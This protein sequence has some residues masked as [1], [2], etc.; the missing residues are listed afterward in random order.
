LKTKILLSLLL[1][2]W[3][4]AFVLVYLH[5]DKVQLV[6]LPPQS[7][8]EWYKPQN[9]RQVWLHNMFKLRREMQAVRRYAAAQDPE[10]LETWLTDLSSHYLKIREMV[11]EWGGRLD[12]GSLKTLAVLQQAE[13]YAKI[14]LALNRLQESCD[15][16]H[17]Q[18]RAVTATLYRAPDFSNLQIGENQSLKESMVTLNVQ[19]NDIKIS[20]QQ[21]DVNQ[22]LGTLDDL[23]QG[24]D[25]TGVLCANCHRDT[26][27]NYPDESVLKA[28]DVLQVRLTLGTLKQQG[29]ALGELAVTACAQ[30][31]GTHRIAYDARKMLGASP[32]LFELLRH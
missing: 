1:L 18:F 8:S 25:A 24:I 22:A 5:K 31:H 7:I 15:S 27:I 9:K 12:T 32:G 4:L 10:Q 20:M 16:C 14:P 21:G 23:R 11:P 19:V 28:L 17:Q 13:D 3:V 26:S 30:C 6:K 29:Q 2:S